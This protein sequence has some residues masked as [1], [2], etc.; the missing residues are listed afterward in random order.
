MPRNDIRIVL[1][2]LTQQRV[3]AIVNPSDPTLLDQGGVSAAIHRVA[4]PRLLEAC[5]ALGGCAIGEAKI[6]P[7]FGLPARW[8]IHTV[9]P[10]WHGGGRG[11]SESLARCYR[12]VLAL[13]SRPELGIRAIA[14]PTIGTAS[15]K[16]P[17][18]QA[19]LIA[20]DE[21]DRFQ[22]TKTPFREIR[23]VCFTPAALDAY[24]WAAREILE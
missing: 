12:N 19:A 4:G 23:F 8:V 24:E 6:T 10:V 11:E 9:T 16:F 21:A 13:A 15:G 7:G 22:A 5:K 14:F 17:L 2:D 3:D 18:D 20:V 1:G